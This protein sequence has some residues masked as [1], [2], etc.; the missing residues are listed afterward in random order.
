M[1][2]LSVV[3]SLFVGASVFFDGWLVGGRI[4]TDVRVQRSAHV[5]EVEVSGQITHRVEPFNE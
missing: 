2:G 5:G 4:H 3:I 1:T